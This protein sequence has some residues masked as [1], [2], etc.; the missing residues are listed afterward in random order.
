MHSVNLELL[1]L[2]TLG[3]AIGLLPKARLETLTTH[4]LIFSFLYLAYLSGLHIWG[5]TFALQAIGVCLSLLGI[6]ALGRV[7][8]KSW[9]R[10]SSIILLGQYSLFSYIA[11]IVILIGTSFAISRFGLGVLTLPV[12]LFIA[13]GLTVLAVRAVH[14]V[15]EVFV[16][17]D[18]VYRFIFEYDLFCCMLFSLTNVISSVYTSRRVAS[19]TA[20]DI[21]VVQNENGTAFAERC[22]EL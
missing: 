8:E 21:C 14:F 20:V 12:T 13:F 2:G 18:R 16:F 1:T 5:E 6:Y 17:V 19:F 22:F 9:H 7:T 4:P 15:R 11:Q 3:I 10:K